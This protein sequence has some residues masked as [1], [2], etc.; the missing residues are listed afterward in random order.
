MEESGNSP[1]FEDLSK[2]NYSMVAMPFE[3]HFTSPGTSPQ[4]VPQ[5]NQPQFNLQPITNM[6]DLIAEVPE[7]FLQNNIAGDF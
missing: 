7:E 4:D 3:D 6:D 2:M 1:F 5:R